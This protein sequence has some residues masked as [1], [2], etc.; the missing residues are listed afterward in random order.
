MHLP[1]TFLQASEGDFQKAMPKVS[2]VYDVRCDKCQV[3]ATRRVLMPV[4]NCQT[5]KIEEW[6]PSCILKHPE[7]VVAV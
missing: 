4:Y 5:W 2:E 3:R 7:K 6:C 1:G